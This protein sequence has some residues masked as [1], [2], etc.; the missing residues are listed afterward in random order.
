MI[1]A[2]AARG[3]LL[4]SSLTKSILDVNMLDIAKVRELVGD[5]TLSDHE[6]AA[7]RDSAIAFAEIAIEAWELKHA[8]SRGGLEPARDDSPE[9]N[10]S[11]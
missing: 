9:L 1:R 10:S 11:E 8:K 3:D 2:A 4:E 7:I 5:P 6:A